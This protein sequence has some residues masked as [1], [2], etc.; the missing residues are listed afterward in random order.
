MMPR[1]RSCACVNADC[2]PGQYR[3]LKT[4]PPT[5]MEATPPT[6]TKSSPTSTCRIAP[7]TDSD[8]RVPPGSL[9]LGSPSM[10]SKR[11]SDTPQSRPLAATSTPMTATSHPPRNRPTPSSAE[12][13]ART[14]RDDRGKA[15]DAG[16][17]RLQLGT[18]P[19]WSPFGPLVRRR[20]IAT[21]FVVHRSI[22][23]TGQRRPEGD[24]RKSPVETTKARSNLRLIRPF[25]SG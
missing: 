4:G 11:S 19:F 8:A 5:N 1:S 12:T 21:S 3:R 13:L 6:G 10:S 18:A 23:H 15:Q 14:H 20:G 24:H 22:T 25:P 2:K 7:D 16:C 9:T 17:E